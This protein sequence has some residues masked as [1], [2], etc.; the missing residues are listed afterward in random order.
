MPTDIELAQAKA[1]VKAAEEEQT[2]QLEAERLE[3][4][5]KIQQYIG[6]H[7]A[8]VVHFVSR[9]PGS[10]EYNAFSC[11]D[12]GRSLESTMYFSA[13]LK[14]DA[15]FHFGYGSTGGHDD[16]SIM[17][18]LPDGR[19]GFLCHN[20]IPR[21]WGEPWP[22]KEAQAN[23]DFWIECS[24]LFKRRLEEFENLIATVALRLCT[25]TGQ[26]YHDV[27]RAPRKKRVVTYV[28]E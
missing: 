21:R 16:M 10:V 17:M 23:R 26:P 4:E 9:T 28:W 8:P 13:K 7:L 19:R 24:R 2:R 11:L 27:W 6:L 1:V 15:V 14:N 18:T 12:F 25:F 20:R 22:E 5:N 3:A